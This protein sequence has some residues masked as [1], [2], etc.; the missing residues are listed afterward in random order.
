METD[1]L[2]LKKINASFNKKVET[3]KGEDMADLLTELVSVIREHGFFAQDI[4]TGNIKTNLIDGTD[5]L[6]SERQAKTVFATRF[7]ERMR[8]KEIKYNNAGDEIYSWKKL[9]DKQAEVL[10]LGMLQH[11]KYNSRKEMLDAL[12]MWDGEERIATFMAKYY[13][14]HTNPHFFLK[15]MTAII[16][17][18]DDPEKNYVPYWFDFV[19]AKGVG[20]T[21]FFERLLGRNYIILHPKSRSDD[22]FV[23]VYTAN[24]IAGV[25]DEN[26]LSGSKPNQM[27]YEELKEFTTAHY[28]TFSRKFCEPETHPRGFVFARTSNKVKN[29]VSV[30]ERR[31]IIFESHNRVNEC[32]IADLPDD[33]FKQMLAEAYAYYQVNGMYHLTAEEKQEILDTNMMYADASTDTAEAICDYISNLRG[34]LPIGIEKRS[35]MPGTYGSYRGFKKFAEEERIKFSKGV[36][37]KDAF[38]RTAEIIEGQM[39]LISCEDTTP[40]RTQSNSNA[41]RL[42]VVLTEAEVRERVELKKLK[43]QAMGIIEPTEDDYD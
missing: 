16:G 15:F 23:E 9:T 29:V 2:E 19:G 10:F 12:P 30:T 5:T 7:P 20:K 27:N 6:V 39:C 25:D 3:V 28:D 37:S 43:Y 40:H 11:C 24:A 33:F 32:L 41:A 14:C 31:Q 36:P 34:A 35:S 4:I 26:K 42:F 18:M 22:M 13:K 1:I 21:Y 38:W 8:I 17:K